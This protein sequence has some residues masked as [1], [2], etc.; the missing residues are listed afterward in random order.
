MITEDAGLVA[1]GAS[2]AVH[3]FAIQS[4]GGDHCGL[5]EAVP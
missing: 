2:A 4:K 5:V 3:P 1:N